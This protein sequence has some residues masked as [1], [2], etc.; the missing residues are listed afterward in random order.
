[1]ETDPVEVLDRLAG[2]VC[3]VLGPELLGLYVHGSWVEGDFSAA[4]SDLDLLAV[5]ALDPDDARATRLRMV[6]DAIEHDFPEWAGRI[7]VEYVSQGALADHHDNDRVLARISPGEPLHLVPVSGHYLPNWYS[8]RTAGQV[9][10][11]PEP[12]AV[13]PEITVAEVIAVIGEH[14][15]RWPDWVRD[16]DSPG[17]QAYAVLTSCRMLALIGD[18]QRLSKRRA[19]AVAARALPDHARLI[20]WACRWWYEDGSDEDPVRTA[21]VRA[22]VDHVSALIARTTTHDDLRLGGAAPESM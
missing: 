17:A 20:D 8:A 16:A 2:D 14:A 4:R 21:D 10:I 12:G 19:A 13:M 15:R 7:E 6:H 11:G 1:M 18:G 5:L 22:F 3:D 9:L